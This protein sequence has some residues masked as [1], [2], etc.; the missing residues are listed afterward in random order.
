M[1]SSFKSIH[2]CR[3]LQRSM[4]K[5][6]TLGSAANINPIGSLRSSTDPSDLQAFDVH[7]STKATQS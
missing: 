7:F 5:L 2:A 3:L 6:H 1:L 4:V